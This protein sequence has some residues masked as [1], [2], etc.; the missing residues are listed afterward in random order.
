MRPST[1]LGPSALTAPPPR[2]AA[3]STSMGGMTQW[4]LGEGRATPHP[5]EPRVCSA[6]ERM[7]EVRH[8]FEH[9]AWPLAAPTK[10]AAS[11]GAA[12][13]TSRVAVAP[14][15]RRRTRAWRNV[16]TAAFDQSRRVSMHPSGRRKSSDQGREEAGRGEPDDERKRCPRITGG[17][18][19][20]LASARDEA[21]PRS[22][23]SG[24]AP[25]GYGHWAA[26]S[27]GVAEGRR[28]GREGGDGC[29]GCRA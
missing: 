4:Q 11:T 10:C 14:S 19:P 6:D 22:A 13:S 8:P 20:L 1:G 18:S 25:G 29:G 3:G 24:V 7:H 28:Q 15:K 26:S 23:A 27:S 12:A 21:S 16:S 9:L 5:L 17:A 2:A